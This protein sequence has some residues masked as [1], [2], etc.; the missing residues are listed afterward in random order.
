MWPSVRFVISYQR[1]NRLQNFHEIQNRISL[2]ICRWKVSFT[3]LYAVNAA[4]S[5]LAKMEFFSI[6]IFYV[7]KTLFA[8]VS[9]N[10]LSS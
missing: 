4:L 9:R 1:L 3:K 7:D 6:F 10:L 5:L 8:D 2:K